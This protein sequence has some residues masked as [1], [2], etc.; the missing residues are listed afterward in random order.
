LPVVSQACPNR[1]AI[2]IE[3]GPFAAT[4]NGALGCRTQPGADLASTDV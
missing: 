3:R 2:R 4:T 1:A